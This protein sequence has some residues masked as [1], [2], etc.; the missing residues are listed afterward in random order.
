MDEGAFKASIEELG[1]ARRAYHSAKNAHDRAVA[2][3]KTEVEQAQAR[4][5]ARVSEAWEAYD[6][7]RSVCSGFVDSVG[8]VALY[9]E[10]IMAGDDVLFLDDNVKAELSASGG[11]FTE[12]RVSGGG[13]S[14]SGAI[15]GDLIAGPAGAIIGG[16]K[17]VKTQN[18]VHDERRLYFSA[19]SDTG[20][21]VVELNPDLEL[22]ARNLI[23][24]LEVQKRTLESRR[25][26]AEIASVEPLAR[27]EETKADTAE[28]E[29]AKAS[30]RMAEADTAELDRARESYEGLKAAAGS[31]AALAER[32]AS[33]LNLAGRIVRDVCAA[34]A[35]IAA[36][37]FVVVGIYGVAT[38]P[39]GIVVTLVCFDLAGA[40]AAVAAVLVAKGAR[41]RAALR[42]VLAC[43]VIFVVLLVIYGVTGTA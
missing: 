26:K 28:L 30:L 36:L 21:F 11:V 18:I 16:H 13:P 23:A 37:L 35:A 2:E 22:E 32:S 19:V 38:D 3:A 5:D 8:P 17:G 29:A 34:A 1:Q 39:T 14:I 41:R 9:G 7:A 27:Y 40:L 42:V 24:E 6:A 4:Y 25:R 20:H 31:K 43:V 33:G 12:T 15:V 10:S